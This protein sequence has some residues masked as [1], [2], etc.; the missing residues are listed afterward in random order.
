[1]F[2]H[3]IKFVESIG[4]WSISIILFFTGITF[5]TIK[6]FAAGLFSKA[7]LNPVSVTFILRQINFI[8]VELIKTTTIVALVLGLAIVGTLSNT[9]INFGATTSIGVVLTGVLVKIAAPFITGLLFIFRAASAIFIDIALMKNNNDFKALKSM[10]ID[11]YQ[12]VFFPRVIASIIS[13]FILSSYFILLS[14]IGSFTL[15][16]FQLNTTLSVVGQQVISALQ[17]SDV[18]SFIFQ[19]FFI[20][21]IVAIIPMYTA[22]EQKRSQLWIIVSM[23]KSML[24]LF[25][26][27]ILIVFIGQ[28]I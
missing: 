4:K 7:F 24:R 8:G 13:M 18:I 16:S 23:N 2:M 5:F 6:I 19:I 28:L 20:G 14:I 21:L 22:M 12:M 3:F 1:M 10:D 15:L 26:M 27:F 17:I 11:E 25:Y 9:L